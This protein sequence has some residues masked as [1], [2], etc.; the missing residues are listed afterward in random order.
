MDLYLREGWR[1]K[2]EY[3]EKTHDNQPESQYHIL[4]MKIHHPDPESNPSPSNIGDK[5]A[6]SERASSNQ[7][8]YYWLADET[9]KVHGPRHSGSCIST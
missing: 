2:P 8:N 4:E 3:L 5:L 9:A 6:W 7:L 1:G